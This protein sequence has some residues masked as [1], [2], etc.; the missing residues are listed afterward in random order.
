MTTINDLLPLSNLTDEE[1]LTRVYL[2][3]EPTPLATELAARLQHALDE[4]AKKTDL[5]EMV[6]RHGKDA[7]SEG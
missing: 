5:Y 2:C 4:L 3:K 7:R 6:M 1:L